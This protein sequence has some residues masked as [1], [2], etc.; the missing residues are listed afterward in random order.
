M[1]IIYDQMDKYV[2]Y[3][4][5]KKCEGFEN[6]VKSVVDGESL[7]AAL[8]KYKAMCLSNHI[9]GSWSGFEEIFLRDIFSKGLERHKIERLRLYIK[10]ASGRAAH[11]SILE[12][13]ELVSVRAAVSGRSTA[14]AHI[15]IVLEFAGFCSCSLGSMSSEPR[16]CS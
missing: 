16:S 9:S 2:T 12:L 13:V 3:Q 7:H 8:G 5:I 4:P 10:G 14:R 6:G 15:S 11:Q 1:D